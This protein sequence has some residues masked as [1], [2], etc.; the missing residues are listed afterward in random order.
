[1]ALRFRIFGAYL[2]KALFVKDNSIFVPT[3][4]VIAISVSK[5]TCVAR[6]VDSPLDHGSN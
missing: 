4:T 3:I 5:C 6:P 2:V 1:M